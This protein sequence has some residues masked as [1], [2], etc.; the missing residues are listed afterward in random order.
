MTVTVWIVRLLSSNK[1]NCSL[2]CIRLMTAPVSVFVCI[3]KNDSLLILNLVPVIVSCSLCTRLDTHKYQ[4]V[5]IAGNNCLGTSYSF[6]VVFKHQTVQMFRY[7]DTPVYCCSLNL[8][9][10]L[11]ISSFFILYLKDQLYNLRANR[12]WNF[13]YLFIPYFNCKKKAPG[14]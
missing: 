1:L 10:K 4:C 12:L 7:N 2:E 14:F 11:S 9:Q 8:S 3:C 5:H 13:A 6:C